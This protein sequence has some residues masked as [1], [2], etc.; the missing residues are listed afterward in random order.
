MM[1]EHGIHFVHASDEWYILA[2]EP[3]PEEE[4]YDGYPQLENGVGMLRLLRQEFDAALALEKKRTVR[5]R[6]TVATGKL[7]APFIRR[8]AQEL[9]KKFEDVCIQVIEIENRFFGSQITVSGLITGRD[10]VEQLSGADLGEALLLPCNM[11]REMEDVFLDDMTVQELQE[12]TGVPV[13]IVQEGGAALLRAFLE[14]F[15]QA[16]HRR[17]QIYEQTDCGSGGKA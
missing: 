11:L 1:R 16:E 12:K 17:R 6:L 13:V 10:L 3:I 7:A 8:L 14:P 15:S 5:H 4:E 2:G 9:Q